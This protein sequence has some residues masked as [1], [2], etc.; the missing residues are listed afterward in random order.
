MNLYAYLSEY[1]LFAHQGRLH[2]TVGTAQKKSICHVWLVKCFP[3]TNAKASNKN[4]ATK[5][6][7]LHVNAFVA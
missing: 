1:P 5:I 3:D 6:H 2:D 7:V 4:A